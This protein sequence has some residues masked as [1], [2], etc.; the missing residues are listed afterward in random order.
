MAVSNGP[1]ASFLLQDA[2]LNIDADDINSVKGEPTTNLVPGAYL[3]DSWNNYNNGT[4]TKFITE[5][6]TVGYKM[7]NLISWNGVVRGI[8]LPQTWYRDWETDRKST[9]LNSSH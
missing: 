7:L 1:N 8:A 9:R 6:G 2:V 5:F 4:P 3:M